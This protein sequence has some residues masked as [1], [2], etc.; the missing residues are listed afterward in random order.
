MARAV[1]QLPLPK[2]DIF[3]INSIYRVYDKARLSNGC[4]YAGKRLPLLRQAAG[5]IFLLKDI[6]DYAI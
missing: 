1:P 3:K 5:Q 6:I 4:R 2:T